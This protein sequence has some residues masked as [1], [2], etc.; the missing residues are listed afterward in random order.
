MTPSIRSSRAPTP[1]ATAS[2]RAPA[3]CTRPPTG[4][5]SSA[6]SHGSAAN[7]WI[8]LCSAYSSH[9][10]RAVLLGTPTL[11]TSAASPTASRA[12]T[13]PRAP[14]A[15]TRPPA[16]RPT[17]RSHACLAPRPLPPTRRTASG[18]PW[19]AIGVSTT[20]LGRACRAAPRAP[21]TKFLLTA[22][23]TAPRPARRATVRTPMLCLPPVY[24]LSIVPSRRAAHRHVLARRRV[25][26]HV[27]D[28]A[29]QH[30]SAGREL[31]VKGMWQGIE[32]RCAPVQP[33]VSCR[34]VPQRHMQPHLR[35]HVLA[36]RAA[37]ARYQLL[38]TARLWTCY[39]AS[40]EQGACSSL[41]AMPPPTRGGCPAPPA[42]RATTG[43]WSRAARRLG[44]PSSAFVPAPTPRTCQ[45]RT[46][47]SRCAARMG[48]TPTRR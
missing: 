16:S 4:T 6:P 13:S 2:R 43:S 19:R 47:A 21:P 31:P 46:S 9:L 29:V 5:A 41:P 25:G 28:L 7:L 12:R 44:S 10:F 15:S 48:G 11:A 39:D 1:S 23:A 24:G 30:R 20:S 17:G 42:R 40:R 3:C 37:V 38:A 35:H 27:H 34:V 45:A 33:V 14:L 8:D 36:V 32:R 22:A 26:Q 18:A